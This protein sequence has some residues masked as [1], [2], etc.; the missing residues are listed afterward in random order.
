MHL[1]Y[2][3]NIHTS[4]YTLS[5][6][7]SKHCIKA[8][9][10]KENDLI[11]LV[12]GKGGFYESRIV[13]AHP[14]KTMVEVLDVKLNYGQRK[15]RLHVA[16]SPL[17]VLDRFEWFLEKATEIGIDMITPIIT[18]R[19]E[20]K[21]VNIDRCN[22]IIESAMKQSIKAYHPILN[23]VIDFSSFI[24]KEHSEPN[25]L[26]AHC[27]DSEKVELSKYSSQSESNFLILIG[28]EGD[29]SKSEID[30]ATD[31]GFLP[32]GLG[33]SR[34]RTETAAIVACVNIQQRYI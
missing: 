3:P 8:L 28:P 33:T 5:E 20:K 1:F 25:K 17:K 19:S 24:S 18:Q 2:T 21:Q 12:D 4:T 16:I 13:D 23:D 9:R 27:M 29:F 26:I 14:K 10:M 15:Y 30:M 32:I 6:E 11:Y 31:R 34:L 22:K 7:E